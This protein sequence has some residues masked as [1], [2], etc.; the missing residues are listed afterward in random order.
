MGNQQPNTL[1]YNAIKERGRAYLMM[2]RELSRRYGEA[3]AIDVMRSASHEHGKLIG[4]SLA[5]FA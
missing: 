5:C 2:F 3:E 4:Q 1:V